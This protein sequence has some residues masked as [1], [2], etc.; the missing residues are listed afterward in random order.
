MYREHLMTFVLV[1]LT[2]RRCVGL[3]D[4]L[5]LATS[6]NRNGEL[7]EEESTAGRTK[8]GRRADE[9]TGERRNWSKVEATLFEE[10]TKLLPMEEGY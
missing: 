1:L 4:K 3:R 2:V 8:E 9:E 10:Q 5:V 6:R 7:M